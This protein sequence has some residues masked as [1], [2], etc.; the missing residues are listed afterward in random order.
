[1]PLTAED[2]EEMIELVARYNY[3]I[4][5]RDAEAWADTFTED[6]RFYVPPKH[7][8]RGREALIA[9]I[10]SFGP[11]GGH[12]WTTNFLIEGDGDDATMLVESIFIRGG[13]AGGR[14]RY[15]N[16]MKRVG[17]RWKFAE[18]KAEQY[19]AEKQDVE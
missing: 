10:G 5:S 14:G 9:F 1:M 3:A 4:D 6:G 19:T 7:D 11:P 17:G 18:R 16:T 13:D 12:H 2:R 8:V 15:V